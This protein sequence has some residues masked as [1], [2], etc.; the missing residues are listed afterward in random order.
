[1]WIVVFLA[2]LPFIRRK[3][4]SAVIRKIIRQNRENG[5]VKELAV[6][7]NYV[8]RIRQY[9]GKKNGRKKKILVGTSP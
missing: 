9:P 5:G 2:I 4:T 6:N 3:R 7:L 1:M 8:T